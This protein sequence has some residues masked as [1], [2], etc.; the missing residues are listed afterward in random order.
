VQDLIDHTNADA[1][2][3]AARGF[4]RRAHS[5]RLQLLFERF[6]GSYN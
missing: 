6:D 5:R 2:Q 4:V 1:I 3:L